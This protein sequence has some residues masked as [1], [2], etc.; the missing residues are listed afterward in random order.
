VS[1][2]FKIIT[3]KAD[4]LKPFAT[5]NI[6]KGVI[7][8]NFIGYLYEVCIDSNSELSLES[9]D[10]EVYSKREDRIFLDY[11][12]KLKFTSS[13]NEK[14]II[15]TEGQLSVVYENDKWK[16]DT[17]TYKHRRTLIPLNNY[18]KEVKKN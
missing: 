5:E 6:T 7:Q 8:V 11:K 18:L 9:V 17:D 16:V 4:D 12:M 3:K 2:V 1:D 10:F 15:E 14:N 13:D